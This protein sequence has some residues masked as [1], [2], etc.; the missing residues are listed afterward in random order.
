M[1]AKKRIRNPNPKPTGRPS[2]YTEELAEEICNA[3]A[4]SNEGLEHLCAANP[5]W[6]ERANIFIW[7]RKYPGFRDKYMSAKEQ[8]AEV[9]VDYMLALANEPHKYVDPDTGFQRTDVPMLRVK[10]DAIKWQASKLAPKRFADKT[11]TIISNPELLQDSIER[12]NKLDEKNKKD[13]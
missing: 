11:E 3:I 5:H 9:Q 4:S 6:P 13:Y 1:V 7:M 12:K 2:L 8:Q 10:M